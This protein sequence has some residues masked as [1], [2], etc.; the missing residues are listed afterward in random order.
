MALSALSH[1]NDEIKELGIRAFE[2]WGSKNSL[3]TLK[4]IS[5]EA[6]W[7]KEYLDQVIHDLSTEYVLFS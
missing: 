5:V 2:S 4:Q 1:K 6:T 7:L 3:E